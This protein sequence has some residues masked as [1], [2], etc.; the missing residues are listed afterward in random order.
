MEHPVKSGPHTGSKSKVHT[1]Q[2]RTPGLSP[3]WRP[4]TMNLRS[5]GKHTRSSPSH[6]ILYAALRMCFGLLCISSPYRHTPVPLRANSAASFEYTLFLPRARTHTHTHTRT[7]ACNLSGRAIRP[8]APLV[9]LGHYFFYPSSFTTCVLTYLRPY[10]RS[11]ICRPYALTRVTIDFT[12]RYF[13]LV[14][15]LYDASNIIFNRFFC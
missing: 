15:H 2:S 8:A 6:C 5:V 3:I 11:S 10:P 14:R 13:F 4:W 9:P 7:L 12:W 1:R